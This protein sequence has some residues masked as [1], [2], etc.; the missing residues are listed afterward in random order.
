MTKNSFGARASLR[1]GGRDYEIYR[2]D[3][4]EKR[5]LPVARLP[6]SLRI[7]LENLLRNEDGRTVTKADIQ[8]FAAWLKRREEVRGKLARFDWNTG[9]VEDV[10]PEAGRSDRLLAPGCA[11]RS[12]RAAPGHR[13][14]PWPRPA[15]PLPAGSPAPSRAHP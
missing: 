5:G 11:R 6:Y 1:A 15:G 3:A 9:Q 7:L 2:L 13:S 10:S 14:P 4:L 12:P 8:G